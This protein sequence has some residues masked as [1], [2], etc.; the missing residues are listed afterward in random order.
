VALLT[1]FVK[2]STLLLGSNS[3]LQYLANNP[4]DVHGPRG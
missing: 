4:A 3:V 1:L 2:K